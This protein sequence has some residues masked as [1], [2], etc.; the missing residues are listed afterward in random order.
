MGMK[1]FWAD[2]NC[3]VHTIRKA[4]KK[5]QV[6]TKG[7]HYVRYKILKCKK[8]NCRLECLSWLSH[9]KACC[10]VDCIH[11][12]LLYKFSIIRDVCER[13]LDLADWGLH[14]FFLFLVW[15]YFICS[16]MASGRSSGRNPI[17]NSCTPRKVWYI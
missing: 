16:F 15:W 6:Y 17:S 2:I 14:S 11:E 1:W 4:H 13:F 9:Y 5:F 8:W 10:C 12:V 3:K 7:T